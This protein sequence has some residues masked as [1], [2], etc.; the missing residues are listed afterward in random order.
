[1]DAWSVMWRLIDNVLANREDI[2]GVTML[3]RAARRYKQRTE[4]VKRALEQSSV[5]FSYFSAPRIE[6]SHVRCYA[7]INSPATTL[8][9]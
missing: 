1:M 8:L 3:I 6:E 7:D 9:S 4:S 2:T 5:Y